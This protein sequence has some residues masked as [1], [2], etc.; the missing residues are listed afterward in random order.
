MQKDCCCFTSNYAS[1]FQ[2]PSVMIL[3]I[4]QQH[5]SIFLS[6]NLLYIICSMYNLTSFPTT[7]QLV[8]VLPHLVSSN[9]KTQNQRSS[10]VQQYGHTYTKKI[11]KNMLQYIYSVWKV[12]KKLVTWLGLHMRSVKV[13]SLIII[14]EIK[15]NGFSFMMIAQGKKEDNYKLVLMNLSKLNIMLLLSLYFV[16]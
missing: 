1:H 2:E 7:M 9:I 5:H 4:Q 15:S 13:Q 3:I 10:R 14:Q 6:V 11:D 8:V 12:D 16:K